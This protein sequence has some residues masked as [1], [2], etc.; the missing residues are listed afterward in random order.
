MTIIT[1][2]D[3]DEDED[4]DEDDDDWSLMQAIE[5]SNLAQLDLV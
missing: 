5:D 4:E 3:E 2:T 1:P